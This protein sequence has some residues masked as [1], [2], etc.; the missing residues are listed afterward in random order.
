MIFSDDMDDFAWYSD[1]TNIIDGAFFVKI[2]YRSKDSH[3]ENTS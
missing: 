1:P 2:V 3:R